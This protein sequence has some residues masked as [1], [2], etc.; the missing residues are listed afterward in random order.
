MFCS[1]C[2]KQLEDGAKFCSGCGEAIAKELPKENDQV[3]EEVKE[4][5]T[6]SPVEEAPVEEVAEEVAETPAEEVAETHAEEAV[7]EAFAAPAP[8]KTSEFAT[9]EFS[10]KPKKKKKG[11]VVV[12]ALILLAAVAAVAVFANDLKGLFLKQFGSGAD[13][14]EYVGTLAAK[15]A[16]EDVQDAFDETVDSAVADSVGAK[17]QIKVKI[18]SEVLELL[19]TAISSYGQDI[20]FDGLEEIVLDME[21]SYKDGR[22]SLTGDLKL[23]DAKVVGIEFIV[24]EEGKIFLKLPEFY[25]KWIYID[26]DELSASF[27][28]TDAAT[29]FFEALPDSEDIGRVLLGYSSAIFE[30]IEEVDKKTVSVE[31]SGISQKVTALSFSLDEE[32]V[33][34]IEKHIIEDAFED[35]E[36]RLVIEQC[37]EAVKGLMRSQA[38]QNEE[39]YEAYYGSVEDYIEEYIDDV[40]VWDEFEK[41]LEDELEYIEDNEGDFSDDEVDVDVYV[42]SKHEV[43]GVKMAFE[44]ETLFVWLKAQNGSE[45]GEEMVVY[46]GEEELLFIEGKGTEKSSGLNMTYDVEVEGIDA[47]TFELIDFDIKSTNGTLKITPDKALIN[48]LFGMD[49]SEGALLSMLIKDISLE[50]FFEGGSKGAESAVRLLSGEDLLVEISVTGKQTKASKIKVPSDTDAERVRD[51]DDIEDI[52]EDV[53]FD[54]LRKNIKDTKLSGDLKDLIDDALD[55]AE[56]NMY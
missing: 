33:R 22:T 12:L 55:A 37:A 43:T 35:E 53:S 51:E 11:F 6:E 20:S 15:D 8:E 3:L 21:S 10:E 14:L 18:G 45:I 40:D 47:V 4:E 25:D 44:G 32:D 36:L 26:N 27:K 38:Y 52:L 23:A 41:A 16:I 29:E 13:Y 46:D 30:N 50:L 48:Q 42:N 19:E 17:A 54:K 7:E 49:S 2:G 24:D 1:K 39:F 5:T 28:Q 56:D 9:P 34:E 31:A